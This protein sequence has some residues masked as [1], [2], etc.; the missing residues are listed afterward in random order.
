M[1]FSHN[2]HDLL[3]LFEEGGRGPENCQ[4][5][6]PDLGMI[7]KSGNHSQFPNILGSLISKLLKVKVEFEDILDSSVLENICSNYFLLFLFGTCMWLTN[8]QVSQNGQQNCY[9]IFIFKQIETIHIIKYFNT[10]W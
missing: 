2:G 8:L 1:K 3:L 4:V 9:Q 5:S 10:Y 7:Q 6:K